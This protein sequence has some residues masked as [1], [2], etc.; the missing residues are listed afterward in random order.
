MPL[1]T[2]TNSYAPSAVDVRVSETPVAV[3]VSV[4]LAPGMTAPDVSRIVPTTDAVSNCAKA[5]DPVARHTNNTA[6]STRIATPPKIFPMNESADQPSHGM[7][8]QGDDVV[9][10]RLRGRSGHRLFVCG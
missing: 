8:R 2:V 7:L 4:T 5:V 3:L 10:A 1:L 9:A 6:A